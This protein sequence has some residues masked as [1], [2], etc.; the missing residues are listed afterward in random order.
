MTTPGE[1]QP[2]PSADDWWTNQ[3]NQ[4]HPAP[5]YPATDPTVLGAQTPVAPA[6]PTVLGQP[7]GF[8]APSQP[9]LP[10]AGQPA[11][12]SALDLPGQASSPGQP[13]AGVPFNAGG[14]GYGSAPNP[15]PAQESY[16]Q[17]PQSGQG[18]GFPVDGPG[19][20]PGFAAA[21]Q[22]GFGP[23]AQPGAGSGFAGYAQPGPPGG[24]SA[25][26]QPGAPQAGQPP[27]PAQSGY[28]P[29]PGFPPAG[30]Q[31]FGQPQG[32]AGQQFAPQGPGGQPPFG[33]GAPASS[34]GGG[35][36]WLW[37]VGAAAVT[38]A[39]WAVGVFAFGG[40]GGNGGASAD[41][42]LRGYSAVDDLC[43]ETDTSSFTDDGFKKATTD[44]SG[45]KY[46]KSEVRKHAVID[47]MGCTIRF[48]VPGS[49]EKY[50][51]A[52]IYT[53]LT[54]HKSTDPGP[55]FTATYE[56]W[57]QSE[58]GKDAT[59]D[60][61]SGL[62]DVAFLITDKPASDD[63]AADVSLAVRDGWVTYHI[64]W[65]QYVTDSS[66]SAKV[67]SATEVAEMLKETAK[68]TMANVRG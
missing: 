43:A 51:Y 21:G 60:K 10:Q 58:Y 20:Q 42:D 16:G 41:A 63:P 46:P 11:G 14:P 56:T 39:V 68:Q 53:S 4:Q 59:V 50:E 45:N 1:N 61:V 30:Q 62:G 34:G 5:P 24:P 57:Q 66:R 40:S 27:Q 7:G 52:A 6:D 18:P 65:S 3:S 37:A 2:R 38:S 29:Q 49:T 32:P 9:S 44:S 23:G 55:E 67:P 19:A 12:N 33:P 15:V 8:G 26:A 28:G 48:E 31:S 22:P 36:G 47:E 64:S 17:P 13:T 25:Y 35:K 54:V